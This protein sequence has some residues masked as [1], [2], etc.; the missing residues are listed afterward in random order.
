MSSGLARRGRQSLGGGPRKEVLTWAQLRQ[1][2]EG[3]LAEGQVIE[4]CLT[5]VS[6]DDDEDGRALKELWDE[7]VVR[8]PRHL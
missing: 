8:L 1:E 5:D 4:R 7:Q 2:L 3:Y 6:F